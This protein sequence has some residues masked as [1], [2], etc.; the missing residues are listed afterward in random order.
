MRLA[1]YCATHGCTSELGEVELPD[2]PAADAQ[3]FMRAL[4]VAPTVET[5][6]AFLQQRAHEH[7]E[8][9][10]LLARRVLAALE[11][12]VCETCSDGVPLEL[13]V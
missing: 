7:P 10:T 13:A 12:H 3:A 4:G 9:V 5:V 11:G 2:V 6:H 8:Q 1:L